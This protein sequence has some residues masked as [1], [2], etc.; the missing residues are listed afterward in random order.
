MISGKEVCHE[1]YRT[2]RQLT[3]AE[4]TDTMCPGTFFSFL[5]NM[6]E[7]NLAAA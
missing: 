3:A 4:C 7:P 5:A 2:S 1:R 6:D